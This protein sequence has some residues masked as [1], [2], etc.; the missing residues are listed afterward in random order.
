MGQRFGARVEYPITFGT[1]DER[2]ANP[3]GGGKGVEREQHEGKSD[4][5]KRGGVA[6]NFGEG[7]V[8]IISNQ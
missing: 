8:K 6:G 7:D 1:W 4:C 2:V 5:V 3:R